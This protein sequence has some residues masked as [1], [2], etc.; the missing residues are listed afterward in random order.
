MVNLQEKYPDSQILIL[1]LEM[2]LKYPYKALPV[3]DA[4]IDLLDHCCMWHLLIEG[5]IMGR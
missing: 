3:D 5:N 2:V 1:T 4:R